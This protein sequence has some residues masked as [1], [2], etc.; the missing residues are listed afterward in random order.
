MVRVWFVVLGRVVLRSAVVWNYYQHALSTSPA[1]G[2][3]EKKKEEEKIRQTTDYLQ[4]IDYSV[5]LHMSSN[6]SPVGMNLAFRARSTGCPTPW[7]G[8][9][10]VLLTLCNGM[11]ITLS[12]TSMTRSCLG[13][14][15]LTPS[16]HRPRQPRTI[17]RASHGLPRPSDLPTSYPCR[18]S[19]EAIQNAAKLGQ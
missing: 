5:Y 13:D 17:P 12:G 3:G 11:T 9:S 1:K 19:A 8:S 6:T 10:H 16:R 15:I 4:P 2:V 18:L 7:D 14:T